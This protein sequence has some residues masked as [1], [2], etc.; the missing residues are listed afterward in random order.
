MN[1]DA[2][3][4]G[5]VAPPKLSA[6]RATADYTV[7]LS[8]NPVSTSA[9]SVLKNGLRPGAH[10]AAPAGTYALVGG[11]TAVFADIQRAVNHDYALVFPVAAIIILLIL[12]LLLRSLVAPM[13]FSPSLTA[14]I[15]RRLVA[16]ACEQSPGARHRL[17]H[18]HGRE[19]RSLTNGER[20]SRSPPGKAITPR[21]AA[22][23]TATSRHSDAMTFT[24]PAGAP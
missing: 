19:R 6:D 4:R 18:G 17:A 22:H 20:Q 24:E 8:Y 21:S 14:L 12:A 5:A 7:T 11:T 9:V 23:G 10:A 16:G 15:G 1:S 2:A 13:F 3:G